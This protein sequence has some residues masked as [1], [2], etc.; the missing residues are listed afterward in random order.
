M[1]TVM[2]S[3]L[4]WGILV[5]AC[6]LTAGLVRAIDGRLSVA[7]LLAFVLFVVVYQAT[8]SFQGSALESFVLS[9]VHRVLIAPIGLLALS[10]A[11]VAEEPGT[12]HPS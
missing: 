10:V 11:T 3:P 5:P 9:N 4:R 7:A 8:W 2:M 1:G 12:S 6:I